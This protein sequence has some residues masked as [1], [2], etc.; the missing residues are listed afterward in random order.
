VNQ[1]EVARDAADAAR[2][3]FTQETIIVVFAMV[4]KTLIYIA[5]VV[6]K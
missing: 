2:I 5:D 6:N 4:V 3:A 1:A